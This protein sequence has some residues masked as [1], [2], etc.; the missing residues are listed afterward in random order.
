MLDLEKKCRETYG[1][2]AEEPTREQ[3]KAILSDTL[4]FLQAKLKMPTEEEVGEFVKKH[5]TTYQKFK[6]QKSDP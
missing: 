1:L 3:M 4:Q 2:S 6:T 5:C